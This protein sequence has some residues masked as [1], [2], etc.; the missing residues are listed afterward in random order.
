MYYPYHYTVG[1]HITEPFMN[2]FIRDAI[3]YFIFGFSDNFFMIFFASNIE[4]YF[5][6]T[7]RKKGYS[8]EKADFLSAGWGNLGSDAVGVLIGE[9][10]SRLIT[11][12][13]FTGPHGPEHFAGARLGQFAGIILG[14]WVGMHVGIKASVKRQ[15]KK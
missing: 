1:Q 4:N 13:L 2:S 6:K 5:G 15:K 3:A 9:S 11:K 10:V 12:H 7:F 8:E 14:C